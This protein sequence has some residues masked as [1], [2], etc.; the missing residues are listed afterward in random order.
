MKLRSGFFGIVGS[1][2]LF[3]AGKIVYEGALAIYGAYASKFFDDSL[4]PFL[5]QRVWPRARP[6]VDWL[7]TFWG[8]AGVALAVALVLERL[9]AWRHPVSSDDKR[10]PDRAELIEL[11]RECVL[12]ADEALRTQQQIEDAAPRQIHPPGGYKTNDEWSRANATHGLELHAYQ[13]RTMMQRDRSHGADL[14]DAI[15]RLRDLGLTIPVFADHP[16]EITG[17]VRAMMLPHYL[18]AYA[19][20]VG[21]MGRILKRGDL[22]A[23]RQSSRDWRQVTERGS[24]A[25]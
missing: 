18:P 11:G 5:V 25:E 15:F 12:A 23:A 20:F 3:G 13:R 21:T 14:M 7:N 24:Q 19:R 2:I 8:G 1:A 6:V 4:S 10:I 22:E 17:E 9:W 16:P